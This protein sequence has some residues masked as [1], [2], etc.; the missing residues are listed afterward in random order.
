MDLG[1]S[2]APEV[3]DR[4]TDRPEESPP[5]VPALGIP[6]TALSFGSLVGHIIR[7]AQADPCGKYV[8]VANVHMLV[9]ARQRP[10]FRDVLLAAD[11]ITPDGMPLVWLMR[12]AGSPRQER[13]AG[14]DLLP[15]IC[16]SAASEEISIYLLGATDEVLARLQEKL[17]EEIPGLEIAGSH[18]PPFRP[19]SELED[20]EIIKRINESSAGILLIAL[21]CPKQEEWMYAHRDRIRPLMIGLGAAFGVHAGMQ[22]RAPKVMQHSGFEWLF[23]LAQ[24]PRRLWRRYLVT[25]TLF[26]WYIL[27]DALRGD[28]GKRSAP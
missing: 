26:G 23:R 27:T 9:E 19:L 15:A 4:S 18:A 25:N 7:A 14:M 22:R 24:E 13:V 12:R 3:P 10:S 17:L 16:A 6:V 1:V 8:C 5:S 2:R 21:G 28:H 20:C 11:V